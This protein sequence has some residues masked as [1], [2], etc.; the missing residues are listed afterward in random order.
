MTP[1]D[2]LHPQLDRWQRQAGIVGIAGLAISVLMAFFSPEQFFRSYLIGFLFW[3][4]IALGALAILMIYH[5]T[6]GAWGVLLRRFLESATR[7]IPVMAVLMLP[8]LFGLSFIYIWAQPTAVSHDELLR[9]KA[10]Y[11]NVPFFV[12]RAVGYFAIWFGL[13]RYLN[14]WSLTEA[15]GGKLEGLSGPGL[16]LFGLTVTF[17]SID[18]AMSLEPHW[19]STVYGVL[20][21]I[22][23]VLSTLALMIVIV[24]LLSDRPPLR[25]FIQPS[26]LHDL[27]NLMFAFVMLW[28]YIAFS[29]FLII[30]SGNLPEEITWYVAR[31][32]NGWEY[33]GLVLVLFHFAIPFALL[34][35]RRNKR[36]LRILATIAAAMVIMRFV[37]LI[38]MVK[39]AFHSTGLSIHI[40]DII[41]PIGLG[42]IWVAAFLRQL[43][44]RPL[45]PTV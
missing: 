30:W 22:G 42:G 25:D 11:L 31:T 40:L 2:N 39:P 43:K 17:A 44:T 20:F 18:W 16:V 27:G 19:L 5:L 3:V 24:A 4:G 15:P 36:R 8:I 12:I 35:S 38:W 29:Q 9:H 6:G 10:A 28:A 34:L 14:R 13:M 32:R 26:H 7:T 37:D 41:A 23:H 45:L 33:V 1:S 21:M